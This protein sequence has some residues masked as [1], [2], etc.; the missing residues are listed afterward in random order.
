MQPRTPRVLEPAAEWRAR[1]V[2]D[3]ALYTEV[4]AAADLAELDI[5]LKAAKRKSDDFLQIGK[6][7]FPLDRLATR[8]HRIEHELIDGRGFSVIRGLPRDRYDND[9]MCLLY[10]GI[11]AHLGQPWAQNKYGHVLGDVTDQGKRVDDPTARGNE[12]GSIALPYHSDGSD[13]VGLMCL[14]RSAEG[15]VSTVCNALAIHNDL[16]REAPELA[17]ELYEPQPYDFRGEQRKGGKAY[18]LVPV[19][20]EW[21]DRLFVRYIRPYI[22]ASQRHPETPRITPR[23]DQAMRRLDEMTRDPQYEV[24]M[25]FEPGDIQ[26]VNNY[27][28]LHGRTAYRD[29]PS[30]GRVRHLKRLWLETDVLRDRPPHF[31]NNSRADW[32]QRRSISR[33]D[34]QMG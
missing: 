27:H 18:Y 15:G 13:L 21:N 3:P 11:G 1:D 30:T 4:L 2:K 25:E 26:F 22:L 10:W 33:L 31:S 16:V 14:Q 23:A 6:A 29:D 32:E 9:E 34:K 5:A 8:L 17:A 24:F 12:L 20:T 19:F 28:V 7:D